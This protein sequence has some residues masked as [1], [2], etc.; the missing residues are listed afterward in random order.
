MRFDGADQ[1]T[2][3]ID[4]LSRAPRTG[5]RPLR[6]SESGRWTSGGKRDPSPGRQGLPIVCLVRSVPHQDVL[7]HLSRLLATAEPEPVRHAH[8]VLDMDR[9]DGVDNGVEAIRDILWRA[10]D[11]LTSS[12]WFRGRLRFKLFTL[13]AWLMS[14]AIP[15]DDLMPDRE[16]S[17]RIQVHTLLERFG[18]PVDDLRHGPART[19]W[20]MRPL[21]VLTSVWFWLA[22]TGRVPLLPSRYRWFMRQPYL[23]PAMSGS[24]LSFARRLAYGVFQQ[25]S[26]DQLSR[27]LVNAFLEDLRRAYRRRPWHVWRTR[28][29]TYPVLLLDNITVT[30]GGYQLLRLINDVRNETGRS[31]P[32]LVISASRKVPPGAGNDGAWT[33]REAVDG[34]HA[35]RTRLRDAHRRR[36][37]SEWYLPIRIPD[38]ESENPSEWWPGFEPGRQTRTPSRPATALRTLARTDLLIGV[39]AAALYWTIAGNVAYTA[40]AVVALAASAAL[41]WGL[42]RFSARPRSTGFSPSLAIPQS[43][44]QRGRAATQDLAVADRD[45]AQAADNTLRGLE[46]LFVRLGPP[47]AE[48]LTTPP[49]PTYDDDPR[50]SAHE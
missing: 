5:A 10:S 18:S 27:L 13:V 39:F 28:R 9:D 26:P 6:S 31:D 34:Y 40:I 12:S 8:V 46:R 37:E 14:L 32:L 15:H 1:L 2:E 35:W 45:A 42:D 25:E 19:P 41:L 20:W 49:E 16:L 3:L 48:L 17:R 50:G 24:F 21:L 43:R 33:A 23:T 11:Q 7:G 30:N 29:R 44:A 38:S 4:E 22:A 47:P 36:E